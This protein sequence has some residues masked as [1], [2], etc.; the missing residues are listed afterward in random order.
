MQNNRRTPTLSP[1]SRKHMVIRM[2]CASRNQSGPLI[3]Q[4]QAMLN[5]TALVPVTASN[6]GSKQEVDREQDGHWAKRV[7]MKEYLSMTR[8]SYS[9]EYRP[10]PMHIYLE[11]CGFAPYPDKYWTQM[12]LLDIYHIGITLNIP[13]GHFLWP[14]MDTFNIRRYVTSYFLSSCC[15]NTDNIHIAFLCFLSIFKI[16]ICIDSRYARSISGSWSAFQ[17]AEN[18]EDFWDFSTCAIICQIWNPYSSFMHKS[19][20]D[21]LQISYCTWDGLILTH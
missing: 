16:I 15:T 6:Q 3:V 2:L 19:F 9:R 4:S 17:Y 8:C 7:Q 18:K 11:F 10:F 1:R 12:C 20:W 5:H 14:S 13:H 21:S